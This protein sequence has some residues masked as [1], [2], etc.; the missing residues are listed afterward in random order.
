MHQSWIPHSQGHR[1]SH[2]P[3]HFPP[4]L[5]GTGSL[6]EL[7]GFQAGSLHTVSPRARAALV[8]AAGSVGQCGIW[9]G[10][11]KGPPWLC[12]GSPPKAF[13]SELQG[14][15]LTPRHTHS[16][17]GRLLHFPGTLSSY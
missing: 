16:L 1:Q 15:D 17:R 11:N 14:A 12:S 6:S 3:S 4:S 8:T 2:G 13:C 7:S 9:R 5:P 10:E